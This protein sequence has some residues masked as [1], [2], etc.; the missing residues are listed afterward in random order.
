MSK[1][2]KILFVEDSIFFRKA[3]TQTLTNE[4][5]EVQTAATGEEALQRAQNETPDMILLDMMLPRLDGMMV[6]RILRSGEKTR[7]I[8]VIVLS[9][10]A[11]ERD[12][13]TAQKLG[14]SH[15]F[16]KDASPITE[17]VTTMRAMLGVVA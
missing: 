4:G 5:F 16:R 1:Q 14:I 12:R 11:M 2:P 9:G 10:N 3:V 6:L 8:P 13:A 7:N 15:Y 17:L